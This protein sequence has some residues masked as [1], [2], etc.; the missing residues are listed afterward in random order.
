MFAPT[1]FV[2]PKTGLSLAVALEFLSS[3][4][5]YVDVVEPSANSVSGV[6]M[7]ADHYYFSF[8]VLNTM[9][10]STDDSLRSA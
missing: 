6:R 4:Q 8:V 2:C 9:T 3:K 10:D 7:N 5:G 1:R